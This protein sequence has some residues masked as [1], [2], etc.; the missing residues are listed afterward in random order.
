VLGVLGR[1]ALGW[2]GLIADARY[3]DTQARVLDSL[4]GVA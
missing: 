1:G 3:G 2:D 4:T